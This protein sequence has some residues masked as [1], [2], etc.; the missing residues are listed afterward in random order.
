MQTLKEEHYVQVTIHKYVDDA[1][2]WIYKN[3]FFCATRYMV[4]E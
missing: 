4:N 1:Q 3:D 2:I